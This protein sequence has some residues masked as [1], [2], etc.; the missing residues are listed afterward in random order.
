MSIASGLGAIFYQALRSPTQV[1]PPVN[2]SASTEAGLC[3]D[4]YIRPGL[5]GEQAWGNPTQF[6]PMLGDNS[7]PHGRTGF[8]P[9]ATQL[10]LVPIPTAFGRPNPNNVF[11]NVYQGSR[12]RAFAEARAPGRTSTP[13]INQS[14]R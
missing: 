8:L 12:A 7:W 2:R 6:W 5:D 13:T 11:R 1:N 9:G 10:V 4:R 14:G 3:G